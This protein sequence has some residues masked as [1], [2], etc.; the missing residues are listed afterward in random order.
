MESAGI[1]TSIF[2][3]HLVRSASTSTAA[4]Q[5]VTTENILNVANWSTESSFQ[6]FY[7]KP[8]RNTEFAKTLLTAT[9]NTIDM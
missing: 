1:D 7:H 3:A 4:M 8:M 9:N 5:G 6:R 2:K